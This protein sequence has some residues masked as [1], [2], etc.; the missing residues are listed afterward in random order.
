[1]S[2]FGLPKKDTDFKG[3]RVAWVEKHLKEDWFIVLVRGNNC[4]L[5]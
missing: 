4:S 2:L 1:M 5:N 3:R